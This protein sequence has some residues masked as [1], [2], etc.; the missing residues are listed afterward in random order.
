MLCQHYLF[1]YPNMSSDAPLIE[2]YPNS[3]SF[4]NKPPLNYDRAERQESTQLAS[5]LYDEGVKLWTKHDLLDI[6]QQ[7]SRCAELEYF[8]VH[9]IDGTEARTKNPMF[10]VTTPPIW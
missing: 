7:L 10:A 5:N 3:F 4:K 2:Y 1:H 9:Q 6:E 8:T